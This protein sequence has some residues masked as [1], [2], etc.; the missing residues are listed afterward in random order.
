MV[1]RCKDLGLFDEHQ[2][3]NIYKQISYKKWRTVEPL[4]KGANA[5]SFEEPLLLKRVAE[6]VFDSGRYKIDEFKADLALSDAVLQALTGVP[7][8]WVKND[9]V[10]GFSPTLKD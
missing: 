8:A 2:I 4:D 6:L 3:T 1:Y 7:L 5:L 10:G 9:E